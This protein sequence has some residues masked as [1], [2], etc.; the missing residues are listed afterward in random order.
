MQIS[1]TSR[2]IEPTGGTRGSKRVL[3]GPVQQET[4]ARVTR[5]RM[6]EQ[7]SIAEGINGNST[8][9]ED[10]GVAPA[11]PAAPAQVD[12]QEMDNEGKK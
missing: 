10:A 8:N 9:G 3:V 7:S 5:Q 4:P 11:A 2:I 12:E 1:E 6:R